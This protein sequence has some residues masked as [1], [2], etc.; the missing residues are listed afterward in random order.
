MLPFGLRRQLEPPPI[1][2]DNLVIL[3]VE[4]VPRKPNIRVGNDDA[5]EA[6]VVEILAVSTLRVFLAIAPI[7]IDRQDDATRRIGCRS[8]GAQC[9]GYDRNAGNDGPGRS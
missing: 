5:I 1:D 3:V 7:S 4:A 8:V 9:G 6:R 2:R